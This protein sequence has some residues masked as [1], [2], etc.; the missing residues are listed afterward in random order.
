MRTAT[1]VGVV[2]AG[3]LAG[4]VLVH[5]PALAHGKHAKAGA[6]M[7]AKTFVDHAAQG[8][9]AEVELGKLATEKASNGD[10]KQFGQRMVD[11]HSKAGDELSGLASS[12]GIPAPTSVT[13][14]KER[15]TIDRLS[16]LSGPA[17][18]RAY[19]Q[20]MV[21]DH[22]HDVSEFKRY[23]EHGDDAEL[24]AWAQKT[25]PT[26]EEHQ[27]MAKSTA[28]NVG[29]GKAHSSRHHASANRHASAE[30]NTER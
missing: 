7:N 24:K 9:L 28:A 16:K 29:A 6:A 14:P 8:G 1:I 15:A 17:F 11:D 26:L 25:L 3:A 13:S 18:D 5:D 20:A 19:M 10:V 12:K 21:A 30:T 4:L 2:S 27:R 22:D 23:A